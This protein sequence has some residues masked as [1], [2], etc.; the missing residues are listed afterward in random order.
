MPVF[1]TA[2]ARGVFNST[3]TLEEIDRLA[4]AAAFVFGKGKQEEVKAAVE[5]IERNYQDLEESY[6]WDAMDFDSKK[7]VTSALRRIIPDGMATSIIWTANH[8]T[9][10]HVIAMRTAESAEIEIRFVF[11]KVARMMK[12]KFPLIYRD[13]ESSE[14]NDGT[15]SWRPKYNKA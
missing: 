7:R 12:K 3:Q 8:R 10:R 4:E 2:G 1:G 15:M 13:F 14:L 6:G 11:D 5:Q 9:I